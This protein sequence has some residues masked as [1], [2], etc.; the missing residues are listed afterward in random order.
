MTDLRKDASE[1]I[2]KSIRAVLPGPNVKKALTELDLSGFDSV[3]VIAVG[4]AAVTMAKAAEEVLGDAITEGFVITKYGHLRGLLRHFKC[5]EAGH[6]T[7]DKNTFR[8]TDEVIE[9]VK[10]LTEKDLVLFLLSGG[11][12][13]LFE[14]PVTS[15]EEL[16]SITGQL[17]Q[18][19][20]DITEINTVRKHLS[21]VKGGRFAAICAPAHVHTVILSD[22]LGSELNVIG[23]GPTCPDPSTG[24]DAFSIIEKYHIR[25]NA[26]TI[27]TLMNETPKALAN[28][29]FSVIGDITQLC[30][31]AKEAC[32]ELG[33]QTAVLTDA[34]TC[35]AR[36]AGSFLSSIAKTYQNTSESLAFIAG[37]ETVVHVKGEGKGGRNQELVLAAASGIAGLKDTCIF[38]V[39]SDGTDG[40]TDA[41]GAL[42]DGTT[43]AALKAE[44]IDPYRVLENNDAYHALKAV[45]SLVVTG[46]TGTNV[47]DLS[48]ILIKRET[49][50]EAAEA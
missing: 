33:Y 23:S 40:P 10:D 49:P 43:L 47:N 4:K 29:D 15:E 5:F 7:P 26:D 44:G 11:A 45:K 36:E 22:V 30:E 50:E 42:A 2:K 28:V 18:S 34:L 35:E 41:A 46:P 6:P 27:E 48:V 38:S 24:E 31:A 32:E 39:G 1:I 13:A 8:A 17:L 12:S 14:K 25:M 20:A 16:A 19:G 3:R 37:G 21:F 9:H